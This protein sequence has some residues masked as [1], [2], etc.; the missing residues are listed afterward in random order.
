MQQQ[1]SNPLVIAGF[2]VMISLDLNR[3]GYVD[4]FG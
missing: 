3:I 4:A 2:L 1:A